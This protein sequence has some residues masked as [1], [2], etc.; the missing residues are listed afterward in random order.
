[1]TR[2]PKALTLALALLGVA[3]FFAP[4]AAYL[5]GQ[6]A[7]AIEKRPLATF[8]DLTTGFRA[9][10]PLTAWSVDHLPLRE[11]AVRVH[12]RVSKDV[13]GES[14]VL[15]SSRS[16]VG[17]G[18]AGR[19]PGRGAGRRP[20]SGTPG[21]DNVVLGPD[22]WLFLGAEF[23]NACHPSRSPA[24]TIAGARRLASI[25]RRSGRRF[26][27][28]IA[29]DK[30]SVLPELVPDDY[31]LKECSER[32]RRERLAA[33]RRAGIPGFVDLQAALERERGKGAEPYLKGDTHWNDRGAV[34]FARAL[35][36]AVDPRLLADTS[37]AR[38]PDRRQVEDLAY[39]LGDFEPRSQPRLSVVR[40]GVALRRP[41]PTPAFPGGEVLRSRARRLDGGAPVY[42]FPTLV[43]GDSYA[44]RSVQ[45]ILP[46]F[47]EFSMF[48]V[49]ASVE[50]RHLEAAEARLID[51]IRRAH[52]VVFV[53]AERGFWAR[54]RG[55]PLG[56]RFLD[57]LAK[58]L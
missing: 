7:K 16:P 25:V 47:A 46:F 36:A 39:Q 17:L 44:D 19:L 21:S 22:G 53:K 27:L 2:R 23:R 52:L 11:V 9:F 26:L 3:F 41:Q 34:V 35:A 32:A 14:L 1:M 30:S 5:A 4:V 12:G 29:P 37:V 58:A 43:H 13:F 49:L 45:Q 20:R 38:G 56:E 48:P 8:P 51:Q 15:G 18:Q 55:S 10:D 31:P 33:L 6:R 40:R 28:L 57:A 54:E 42:E 24:G 50:P